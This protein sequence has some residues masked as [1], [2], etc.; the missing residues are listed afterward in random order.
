MVKSGIKYVFLDREKQNNLILQYI[1]DVKKHAIML[2]HRYE[3]AIEYDE[4]IA[5]SYLSLVECARRYN[6]ARGLFWPYV[7][8]AIINAF[9][10]YNKRQ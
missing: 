7:Y 10:D 9:I 4:C 8:R 2:Y 1:P 5:I 6:P 3:C